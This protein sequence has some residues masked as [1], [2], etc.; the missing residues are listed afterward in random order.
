MHQFESKNRYFDEL[1]SNPALMW[2]GQNT[3]HFH[4]HPQV[5]QAM[6][7]SIRA[8]EYHAYAPP[9]G[10]EELRRLVLED[11][12]AS[13][14]HARLIPQGDVIVLEDLGSTN[15]TYLNGEPL[16]GAQPLHEGDRIRIGD[17]EFTFER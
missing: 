16:R 12:F 4:T 8:Q 10:L 5:L 9:A 7:D 13:T 17:S 6:T 15:G 3:N 2:L 14:R 1:F 11:A